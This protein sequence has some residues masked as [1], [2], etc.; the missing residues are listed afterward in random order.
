MPDTGGDVVLA[1]PSMLLLYKA[2]GIEGGV[3]FPV[4]QQTNFQPEEK[5]RFGVN[6]SYFFWPGKGKGH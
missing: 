2:Y 1:G 5:F 6:F 4:Y 3:L